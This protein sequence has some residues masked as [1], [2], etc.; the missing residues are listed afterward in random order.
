MNARTRDYDVIIVGGGMVGAALACLLA[1]RDW[2]IAVVEAHAAAEPATQDYEIRV[3]ALTRASINVL[4]HAG[5]WADIAAR[6][7]GPYERMEVW[8][9]QGSG[10]IRFDAA[11]SAVDVL[12]YIVENGVIQRALA[13]RAQSFSQL[14]W[15][16]PAQCAALNVSAERAELQLTDGRMLRAPLIVGADGGASWVRG[17]ADIATRGWDYGQLGVVTTVR[18]QKAHKMTA[19]QRFLPDGPLAFL[20]LDDAHACSIVWSVP[21]SRAAELLKLSDDEFAAQ[22]QHAF[23]DK[24]GALRVGGPRGAHPL[25]LQYATHYVQPR[26][27]LIGDAAHSIHPLAGQGVNLGFL[28]A[29]TLAQNILDARD[30][31][32]DIG[33]MRVLRRYERA[34]KGDNMAVMA[35]M[36]GFKRLFGARAAPLV[37]ARNLGL[38]LLDR[39]PFLK[40]T[41]VRAALGQRPGLPVFA[42]NT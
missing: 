32:D 18:T 11:E 5:A 4:E 35:L 24:L 12:G 28:D 16:A 31:G 10:V 29:A 1:P 22:L 42:K 39:A 2:D 26:V 21:P 20:P 23:G 37:G 15:L 36:D 3:S 34:R 25:R 40:S 27:A 8:D 7:V 30:T 13:A 17:Q 14:D 33:E 38:N 19:W 9:A 41:I 6:R